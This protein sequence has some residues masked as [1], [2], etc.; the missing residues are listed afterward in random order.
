MS[1]DLD[2]LEAAARAATPGPWLHTSGHGDD[3]VGIADEDRP[4]FKGGIICHPPHG[5]DGS[6][7]WW[8]ANGAY[9]AALHPSAALALIARVRRAEAA[10]REA[11]NALSKALHYVPDRDAAPL[12][13]AADR[14]WALL[15]G[16][17]AALEGRSDGE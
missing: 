17:T 8:P 1:D 13:E 6:M 2:A 3:W 10:L 5:W 7:E 15:R 16:D 14:A 4:N 12:Q 11:S 9:I